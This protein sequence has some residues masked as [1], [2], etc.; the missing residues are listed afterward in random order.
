MPLVRLT[1]LPPRSSSLPKLDW[2]M[3]HRC[4]CS[5][6]F[7]V[8]GLARTSHPRNTP[9][10]TTNNMDTS[11]TL[12][13]GRVFST[14]LSTNIRP[15]LC[16]F[17][18]FSTFSTFFTFPHSY[19]FSCFSHSPHFLHVVHFPHFSCFSRFSN[20]SHC[21]HLPQ[22]ST[23]FTF[24]T[25]E[26]VCTFWTFS[27]LCCLFLHFSLFSYPVSWSRFFIFPHF[28]H[29]FLFSPHAL[30]TVTNFVH[31][32]SFPKLSTFP[33]K[34]GEVN[35]AC[36]Q[37]PVRRIATVAH[38]ATTIGII[39][40]VFRRVWPVEK[41]HGEYNLNNVPTNLST[42]STLSSGCWLWALAREMC[43]D[44]L[45][46]ARDVSSSGG[47]FTVQNRL[48][49]RRAQWCYMSC[50][51]R[52]GNTVHQRGARRIADCFSSQHH[53]WHHIYF[54]SGQCSAGVRGAEARQSLIVAIRFRPR[55]KKIFL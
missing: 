8:C 11:W 1:Y 33:E 17:S 40:Q 12:N 16:T 37:I 14:N 29:P 42:E 35:V 10:S 18:T 53:I 39:S 41:W 23:I 32:H 30:Y 6:R 31:R 26:H 51:V 25:F 54:W 43:A 34:N 49:E 45:R 48:V 15:Q 19:I 20:I 9:N 52:T 4:K 50:A 38:H 28:L 13:M 21:A 44:I 27:T 46:L 2:C 22:F 7:T 36:T 24:F 55:Y 3:H 47:P 5:V